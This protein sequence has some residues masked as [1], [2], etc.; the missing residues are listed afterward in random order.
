MFRRAGTAVIVRLTRSSLRMLRGG[1]AAASGA[2][3]VRMVY[4]GS[5]VFSISIRISVHPLVIERGI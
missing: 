2:T 3:L 1:A 4:H 5:E